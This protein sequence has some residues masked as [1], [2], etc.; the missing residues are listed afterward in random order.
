VV[1]EVRCD[2]QNTVAL[3]PT[4]ISN[5]TS[6]SCTAHWNKE[7]LLQQEKTTAEA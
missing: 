7:R 6:C 1:F 2:L 5:I 4:T 3:P